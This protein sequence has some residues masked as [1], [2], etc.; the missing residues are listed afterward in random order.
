MLHFLAL[1][2]PTLDTY[3][4]DRASWRNMLLPLWR[5][6]PGGAQ[7]LKKRRLSYRERSGMLERL[8]WAEEMQHFTDTAQ[9][10]G[11]IFDLRVGRIGK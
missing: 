8:L 9:Q 6:K 5:Y 3:L 1:G 2:T 10:I 7:V 11:G 4:N